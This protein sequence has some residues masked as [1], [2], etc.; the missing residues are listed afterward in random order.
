MPRVTL[1]ELFCDHT[2]DAQ[3]TVKE[4]RSR[5]I[6]PDYIPT[7]NYTKQHRITWDN[8]ESDSIV[9]ERI[10]SVLLHMFR[11]V[12]IHDESNIEPTPSILDI[13]CQVR[14]KTDMKIVNIVHFDKVDSEECVFFFDN[15]GEHG[16]LHGNT[17]TL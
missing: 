16:S 10:L 3:T 1:Q 9:N 2:V 8:V 15:K 4:T 5:Y 14:Q 13:M 6:L 11:N 7:I 17:Q 12:Y